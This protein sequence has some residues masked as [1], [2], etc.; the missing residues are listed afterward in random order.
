MDR[1]KN[2]NS[3]GFFFIEVSCFLGD[4]T[5]TSA[6]LPWLAPSSTLRPAFI[7]TGRISRAS[8]LC[9]YATRSADTTVYG[10]DEAL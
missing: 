4:S 3:F 9:I 5:L 7:R 1:E 10:N 2:S 8:T 6:A